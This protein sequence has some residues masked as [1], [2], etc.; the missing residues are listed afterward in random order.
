MTQL[1]FLNTNLVTTSQT[2]ATLRVSFVELPNIIAHAKGSLPSSM[3]NK[4]SLQVVPLSVI[5]F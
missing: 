4:W 1:N 5:K 2:N 3:K